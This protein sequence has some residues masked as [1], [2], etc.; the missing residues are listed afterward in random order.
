MA[1]I[2]Q[3]LSKRKAR[4]APQKP[5]KLQPSS[6][7]WVRVKKAKYLYLLLLIPVVYVF[8]FNYVPMYGVIMAFK[9]FTPSLGI[10]GSEWIG[11]YNFQRFFSSPQCLNILWNT[12]RISLYSMIASFPFPIILALGINYCRWSPLKRSVQSITFMPYFLSAVLLV[13]LMSQLLSVRNGV[14]NHFLSAIGVTPIDF[15]GNPRAFDHIYVWSGIWQGTGYSAII[16]I[17]ALAGIDPTYHEAAM[18]DGA[19]IWQR[20][21][22]IDLVLIRPTIVLL[23]I[24]GVGSILN[25]G[26]EKIYLMQNSLNMST[27]SVISTYVYSVSLKA[28]RP[29]YSFGTAIGLFQNLVGVTLTLLINGISNK[30]S[31]EGLF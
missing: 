24:L 12:I 18:I 13:G 22:R 8:I 2:S 11:L 28:S 20:I 14:V 23:L 16:Y 30:I 3:S 15:M 21:W 9:R 1:A 6:S 27:S 10:M 19:S 25:I 31:G 29:D 26:F 7:L 4:R 17:S 5:S